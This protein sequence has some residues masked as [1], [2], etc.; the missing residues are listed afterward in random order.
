MH[1]WTLEFFSSYIN[2]NL[3]CE[4]ESNKKVRFKICNFLVI[5]SS[6]DASEFHNKMQLSCWFQLHTVACLF[7]V[8]E[9]YGAL[10]QMEP[11]NLA[12]VFG[13]TLVRTSEDNMTDMV[14]HM[15]DRYKIVE[16]LIQHVRDTAD[17]TF[18][19]VY[20]LHFNSDFK[21]WLSCSLC[22]MS[23]F[24]LKNTKRMKRFV[25]FIFHFIEIHNKIYM[26]FGL[27]SE[28]RPTDTSGHRG[29]SARPKHRSPPL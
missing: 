23:G 24:S 13:P 4:F 3:S 9:S 20:S 27:I 5:F 22:S 1:N 2:L 6:H 14:T 12:L 8:V 25:F 15:P 21:Q 7:M 16:T 17:K 10:V 11:R 28:C 26:S 29:C 18:L 19:W